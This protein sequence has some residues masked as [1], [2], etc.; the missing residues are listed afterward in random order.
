M[1]SSCSTYKI[2][3]LYRFN[4]YQ[5]VVVVCTYLVI[6]YLC[7]LARAF[8]ER[9]GRHLFRPGVGW[10]FA[11]RIFYSC[12]I[13]KRNKIT[14]RQRRNVGEVLLLKFS[15]FFCWEKKT[16]IKE[17]SPL[18]G[19]HLVVARVSLGNELNFVLM[20]V[21]VSELFRPNVGIVLW[22]IALWFLLGE[23]DKFVKFGNWL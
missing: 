7:A 18:C 23:K 13:W 22:G 20:S 14:L 8:Q 12:S 17:T 10:L 15:S 16:G 3:I 11:P 4:K 9:R 6:R 19:T 5:L 21:D 2:I 1:N